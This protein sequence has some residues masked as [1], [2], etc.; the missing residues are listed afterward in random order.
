MTP[1][2]WKLPASAPAHWPSGFGIRGKF[3]LLS[4]HRLKAWPT[5]K[6]CKASKFDILNYMR[7]RE[8]R[9]NNNMLQRFRKVTGLLSIQALVVLI[10]AVLGLS[11]CCTVA[12]QG[13]K[14]LE[15]PYKEW[16]ERDVTYI[17]TRQERQIFLSLRTDSERDKFI[18]NF[19][20]LR[21]STP[22]APSN[23][24]KDEH[25]KRI[26]Y[27]NDHFGH[28][29]GNTGWRT[30]M[31]RTY[32]V[33]GPPQQKATYHD[34]Q[35]I[36]PMEVWFY[37]NGHAA[38]PPFF[39]VAFY[40]E[41]N[42]SE[43]KYYSPYFDG[44]QKLVTTRGETRLQAWQRI[45]KYGGRELAR[46]ALSL[47]P[48]EPVDTQNA[49]AS[50]QSDLMLG[51]LRD[52]ANNPLSIR[53]LDMRRLSASVRSSMISTTDTLGLLTMPVR[54][55]M[56]LTRV[57]YLLRFAKPE[58]FT[59]SET[60]GDRLYFN[61]GVR[62][63]VY[64]KNRKLIFTQD[65]TYTKYLTRAQLLK[66]KERV[67]GFEGSLP[68]P[69]GTYHLELQLTDWLKKVSYRANGDVAVPPIPNNGLVVSE[70]VPF[71][72][73]KPQEPPFADVAPFSFG[74]IHFSPLLHRE[75]I[76][77]AG[78]D[79]KFFYQIWAA[80]EGASE[81]EQKLTVSY[82]LGRPG[83]SQEAQTVNDEVSK[84]QFDASGSLV[85]G[86]EI[87]VGDWPIGN[88]KLVLTVRDPTSQ[89]KA[90]ST[91]GFRIM[92]APNLYRS[93]EINDAVETGK[94]TASGLREYERG[95]CYL[96]QEKNEEAIKLF[97]TALTKNH[98]LPEALTGL[99]DA[100]FS[101]REYSEVAKIAPLIEI[102]A[103]TDERTILRLAQSLDKNGDTKKAVDLLETAAK[104]KPA[105]GVIDITLGEYY[106]RLGNPAKAQEYALKG[107]QLLGTP[108]AQ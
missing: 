21:N 73:A 94:D 6:Q 76:F 39:Y 84:S 96:V 11:I 64:D 56:G 3:P 103:Q 50:M 9:E 2:W 91:L 88:Y 71:S 65:R 74:G 98:G 17:I 70:I 69:P 51:T 81:Q 83:A 31:G 25:Y 42:F 52:L 40:R 72:G 78:S 37:S 85:N 90:Y 24:F 55:A 44:P 20:E 80:P 33:L 92:A 100:Q 77:A 107:K 99:V 95:I 57:D 49:T 67:F 102:T 46:V 16:L 28:E 48:D 4:H 82:V 15:K 22:G 59:L 35:S 86:K 45:D 12:A 10:S 14:N 61:I 66:V 47:I 54:D 93:W 79:L 29:S 41:D 26:T 106:G 68:L 89:E 8:L 75:S 43:Y 27:A 7:A 5:V 38:L 97:Q 62:A 23:E 13:K 34:S 105:S 1:K 108:A 32:I 18:E 101:R 104:L 60:S 30:D 87:P 36:R 53:E 63:Q 58:D 19:W